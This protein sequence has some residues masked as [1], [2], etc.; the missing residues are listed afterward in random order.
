MDRALVFEHLEQARRHVAEG[1]VHVRRQRGIVAWLDAHG[2]DAS[3]ARDLLATYERI[4]V[5]H[6]A[7]RD[8]LIKELAENPWRT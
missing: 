2:L 7:D 4:L 8:R 1:A 5:M 6:T 3:I